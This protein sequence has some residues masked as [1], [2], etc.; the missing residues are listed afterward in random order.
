MTQWV[1]ISIVVSTVVLAGL[2]LF[3]NRITTRILHFSFLALKQEL[4]DAIERVLNGD[5]PAA[6][7]VTP[8]QLMVMDIIKSKLKP[9]SKTIED[10][11]IT[12]RDEKG[13]FV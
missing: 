2:Q 12:N 7:P 8:M 4:K 1:I 10:L 9:Q 11:T 13:K 6:E 5:L 3:L